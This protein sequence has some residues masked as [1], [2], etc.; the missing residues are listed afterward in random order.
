GHTLLRRQYRFRDDPDRAKR[1][2][3]LTLRM[4]SGNPGNFQ[5]LGDF[6]ITPTLVVSRAIGRNDVHMNLGMEFD[7]AD[8]ERTRAHN[9]IGVTLQPRAWLAILLDVLGS[10]G[11]DDNH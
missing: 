7:T 3:A 11:L 1:D 6:T 4:P 9:A 2:G 8:A 10:S 5:G